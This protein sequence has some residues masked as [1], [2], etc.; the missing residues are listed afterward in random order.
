MHQRHIVGGG[1][2]MVGLASY[3][4]NFLLCL[5]LLI[6]GI[7]ILAWDYRSKSPPFEMI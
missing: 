7:G 1:C 5:I 2:I 6:A 3:Y 4:V